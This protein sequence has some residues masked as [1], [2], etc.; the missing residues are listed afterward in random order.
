MLTDARLHRP[1]WLAT[2]AAWAVSSVLSLALPTATPPAPMAPVAALVYS[3]AW[4]LLAWS[5]VL[6]SRL[7]DARR[8]HLAG[9]A[10]GLAAAVTGV[11]N[12]VVNVLGV[13]GL[14]EW[15]LY[16]ILIATVLLVPFAYLFARERLLRLTV[17]SLALF[18]AI[19]F[20]PPALAGLVA[21]LLFGALALRTAWFET[22]GESPSAEPA[23]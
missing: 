7:A 16:G 13:P 19:G 22:R 14:S 17:F 15:Y 20:V 11:A 5:V 2:G 18:L 12:L 21:L 3:I 23:T 6:L 4:L 9:L 8:T 1:V 10:I